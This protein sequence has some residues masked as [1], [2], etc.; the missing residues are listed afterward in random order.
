V[1]LRGSS[2]TNSGQ[3]LRRAIEALRL[4]FFVEGLRSGFWSISCNATEIASPMV[5]FPV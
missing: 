1:S 3:D 5:S 2:F 4:K